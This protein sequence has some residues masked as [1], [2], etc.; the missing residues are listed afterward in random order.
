MKGLFYDSDKIGQCFSCLRVKCV[1]P[2]NKKNH[3]SQGC[4]KWWIPSC[5]LEKI[6]ESI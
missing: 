2:K 1:E 5:E 4:T 3:P 6:N